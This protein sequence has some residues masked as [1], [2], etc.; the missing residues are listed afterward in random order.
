M[1]RLR[2]HAWWVVPTLV[3]AAALG[4]TL[5]YLLAWLGY[6]AFNILGVWLYSENKRS[7]LQAWMKVLVIFMVPVGVIGVLASGDSGLRP[8]EAA[9]IGSADETT[10]SESARA[11]GL[12]NRGSS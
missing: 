10:R 4:W 1:G 9:S 5:G 3:V 8:S 11:F 7:L 12:F 2:P 6:A